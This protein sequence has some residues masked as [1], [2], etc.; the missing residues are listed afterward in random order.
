MNGYR[1]DHD[2]TVVMHLFRYT[3]QD[4]MSDLLEKDQVNFDNC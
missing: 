1:G 2:G 4:G 3:F